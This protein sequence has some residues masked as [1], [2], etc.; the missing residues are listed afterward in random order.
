MVTKRA[1]PS[2]SSAASVPSPAEPESLLSASAASAKYLVLLQVTSRLL[3]F[4]VNQLLLRYLNPS[5]LGLSVQLELLTTSILYFSRESLRNALQRQSS[6]DSTVVANLALLTLPLGVVFSA[7]LVVGYWGMGQAEVVEYWTQ[8]VALFVVATLLELAAEPA[9][10][11]AQMEMRVK[12][13]AAAE[14][15]AALA[16][17][18]LTCG[19]TI[20]AAQTGRVLGALPFA[21]GQLGYGGILL[22]AYTIQIGSSVHFGPVEKQS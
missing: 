3:T 13:R 14:S 11:V 8:S 7:V 16:R 2:A 1:K 18:V 20:W 17:C 5:L 19:V 12:V 15:A 22:V 6:G 9:F 21:I 10:A 4:G